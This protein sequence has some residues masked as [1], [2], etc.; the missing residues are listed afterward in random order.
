MGST[1]DDSSISAND[2]SAN[3]TLGSSNHGVR[4][5]EAKTEV[6]GK[7]ET[8]AVF[9]GKLLVFGV[10]LFSALGVALVVYYYLSGAEDSD[11]EEQFSED[12]KKVFE[13]IGSSLDNML[14][15]T[16]SFMVSLVSYAKYSNSSWPFVTM[17]DFAVK[18]AKLLSLSKAAI[19]GT[20]P[21]VQTE[22]RQG[23][24]N[25]SVTHDN[26]VDEGLSVQKEDTNF[27]GT[28][29]EEWSGFGII[30]GDTGPVEGP[31]PYFPTWHTAPV[32][33]TYSP[34]NWNLYSY[35]QKELDEAI[36]NR[37]VSIA[38]TRN[39]PDPS[40]AD[41]KIDERNVEWI[42]G[43]IGEDE[44]PTEPMTAFNYP[45]VDKAA[46]TVNLA[47]AED[48]QV[49]GVIAMTIFWRELIKDILPQGS[50]GIV[51]VIGNECNQTFSYQ[52]MGPEATYLGPGDMHDP[53]YDSYEEYSN[54]VELGALAI[55]DRTY[56]GI[57]FSEDFCPHW[58]KAYPSDMMRDHYT[59][60]DP[61]LFTVVAVLIFLFTA[62][63]FVLYDFLIERRQ[64]KVMT[65][66]V[67]SSAI[68]SSLFP[69][70]VRDRLFP[71]DGQTPRA[72]TPKNLLQSFFNDGAAKQN[73]SQVGSP[74]DLSS[75]PIAD[76]FSETTVS[77]F[78]GKT[79]PLNPALHSLLTSYLLVLLFSVC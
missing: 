40:D 15:A 74:N 72:E 62:A 55:R 3:E 66:A 46:D 64:K 70:V 71:I 43:F 75:S 30:H 77:K 76:L 23:W 69:S 51:V 19:V 56:T 60:T 7:N 41:G 49:V 4:D 35:F 59:S 57:T 53:D 38:L 42:K 26:W 50:D 14:G 73:T 63:V 11:F 47:G 28:N 34:Y 16:D 1:S 68:V 39:L 2:I 54:F 67:Q 8:K 6:I 44:D 25:Y 45:I 52:I 29:F 61:V 78:L 33:P 13:E 36:Q 18:A 21:L 5:Q 48:P 20:Y 32:V 10:M 65:T 17:P 37:R 22:Q 79:A 9:Y 58:I 24:E 12:V 27:K 31:G